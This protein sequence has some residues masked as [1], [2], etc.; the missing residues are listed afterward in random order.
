MELRWRRRRG[1][2]HAERL[3]EAA[4]R[5]NHRHRAGQHRRHAR[6]VV[7]D[8]LPR[9][10]LALHGPW[11][12]LPAAHD[13]DVEP[14]EGVRIGVLHDLNLPTVIVHRADL[15]GQLLAELTANRVSDVFPRL[16]LA[17]WKLPGAC[18]RLTRGAR[19]H[20]K[21]AVRAKQ[22]ADGHR[23]KGWVMSIHDAA[24]ARIAGPV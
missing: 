9:E 17:A 22:D 8:R 3:A 4:E 5:F 2:T 18:A 14:H 13:A 6:R 1:G 12:P 16:N 11:L 15:D 24:G 20:Q 10:L 21:P 23:D 19:I 7:P